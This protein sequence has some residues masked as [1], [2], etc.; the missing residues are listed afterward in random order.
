MMLLP[1]DCGEGGRLPSGAR[2]TS[3][4]TEYP[5]SMSQFS[6]TALVADDDLDAGLTLVSLLEV[7]GHRVLLA[8]DGVEA[9]AC[10]MELRPA[11]VFLDI[12]MPHLD[13]WEVCR[14]IRATD[15][16][17]KVWIVAVTGHGEKSDRD[18]SQEAGFNKHCTKPLEIKTVQ[19]LLER[20]PLT[21]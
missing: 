16:G 9:L 7:L 1:F 4:K 5:A 3:P 2:R 6:P 21:L 17:A 14:R 20:T 12:G 19:E 10:A 8:R 13:G 18:K 15:W 11:V